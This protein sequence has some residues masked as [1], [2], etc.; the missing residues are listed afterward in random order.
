MEDQGKRLL[1]AVALAFGIMLVWQILFPVPEPEETPDTP[2]QTTGDDTGNTSGSTTT[3]PDKPKRDVALTDNPSTTVATATDTQTPV[4]QRDETCLQQ[5]AA[6]PIV[7]NFPAYRA[8]FSRCGGTLASWQL[9]SKQFTEKKNG[10]VQSM[11]LMRTGE[12]RDM[13]SFAVRFEE[14]DWDPFA[15]WTLAE[16]TDTGVTFTWQYKVADSTGKPRVAFELTKRYKLYPDDFLVE[17]SLQVVNKASRD[18]RQTVVVSFYGYQDPDEDTAGG[19]T[20]VDSAWRSTCYINGEEDTADYDDVETPDLRSGELTWGGFAHSYFLFVAAPRNMSNANYGCNSLSAGEREDYGSMRTDIVF[21]VS[22]I[23]L[24]PDSWIEQSM[25]AYIGPKYLDKL[26]SIPD[27]VGY[28]PEFGTSIDFPWY[29]FLARPLLWLLQWFNSFLGNWGL[30]I[31]FLT[32]M[33]KLATLYWATKSMRSMKAMAR[34]AP[35]IKALQEKHKNDKPRLQQETMNL[36]KTHGVNPLA[37]CL[38]I[39]LQ[40]PIWISLYRMLMYAGELYH[41]PF[42]PGW[43]DDLTS[44]DPY[45]ILPISLMVVMFVQAKLTPT[46]S[47]STQQKIMQWGMPIMF[48]VFAFFFPAGLTLYIFTNTLLSALHH[49]WMRKTDPH[50][51]PEVSSPGKDGP[52]ST[53]GR[54]GKSSSGK[55]SGVKSAA[56]KSSGRTA[57]SKDKS[58]SDRDGAS[59][60]DDVSDTDSDSADDSA[61]SFK[62]AKNPAQKRSGSGKKSRKKRSGK[63]SKSRGTKS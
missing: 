56:S 4:E 44:T 43:V 60:S 33:V 36:Y 52:S 3:K 37:G 1:L 38:P 17:F 57:A 25:I 16:R 55:R 22:N 50:Q 2:E 10:K 21:P 45:Y 26:D 18:E 31:I 42:V 24:D 53:S 62:P 15:N 40:M 5:D 32:F 61:P 58:H 51:T 30:S 59:D 12:N 54:K 11:D 41:A 63:R 19:W 46:T 27:I 35:Q 13:R 23:K 28:D 34:L 6:E 29:A 39:L 8:T 9:G 7:F 14:V 47:S 20:T 48:G 49:L